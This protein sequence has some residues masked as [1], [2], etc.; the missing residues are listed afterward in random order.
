MLIVLL[1]SDDTHCDI[2]AQS[3]ERESYP[4]T[5]W[6]KPN[7]LVSKQDKWTSWH[8]FP[9]DIRY[10]WLDFVDC[11]LTIFKWIYGDRVTLKPPTAVPAN[12]SKD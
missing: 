1:F 5:I 4:P 11:I 7:E 2:S 9:R 8:T 6:T 12:H 3:H 10:V